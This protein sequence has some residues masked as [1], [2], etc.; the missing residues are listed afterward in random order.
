MLKTI[1]NGVYPTMVTPY[2]KGNKI[3]YNAVLKL[4]EWYCDRGVAGI[5]A[6]CQSSEIFYL[7]LAEKIEL[8]DFIVKNTPKDITIIAS[9]HTED[10]LDEQIYQ[11]NKII[12]IGI[13]AY[14]FI[15]NRFA[16]EDEDD[17][18]FLN[19]AQY[20]YKSLPEEVGLG[21]Y[22]CPYPYKRLLSPEVL[23][24][25]ALTGRFQFLKDTC[26]DA[27]EIGRKI[28]AVEGTGLKIYNANA[29]T[30]LDTMRLGCS[31]YSGVMANFHPEL[32]AWLCNNYEKEPDR[33]EIMQDF[34]GF[35]S[36]AECQLYPINSKYYLQLEGLGTEIFSRVRDSSEFIDSRKLETKQMR[37]STFFFKKA[38]GF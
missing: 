14:V 20:V 26:C 9:G 5:F 21:I 33:A 7:T 38:F 19:N 27:E 1:P 25:L 37:Q 15:A 16:K 28:L 24:E 30:L 8:L 3:D 17:G 13:D 22:E 36:I 18:V 32:Y 23:R 34:L 31:G 6:I 12:D 11:A 29:A 2:T 4:I 35:A 10:D